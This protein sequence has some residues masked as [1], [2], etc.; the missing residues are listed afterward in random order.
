MIP[1]QSLVKWGSYYCRNPI[2]A[3]IRQS[4][5][6]N[7][8]GSQLQASL[9]SRRPAGLSQERHWSAETARCAAATLIA[10][11][12]RRE[13]CVFA[14]SGG[15]LQGNEKKSTFSAVLYCSCIWNRDDVGKKCC[16]PLI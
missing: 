9:F 12:Y 1:L 2:Q 7:L 3:L 10:R 16:F 13:Q 5:E 6:D 14:L 4:N 15:I 11:L 8:P